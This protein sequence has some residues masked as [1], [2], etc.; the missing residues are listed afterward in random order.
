MTSLWTLASWQLLIIQTIC[1]PYFLGSSHKGLSFFAI[2]YTVVYSSFYLVKYLFKNLMPG[3]KLPLLNH[4]LLYLRKLCSLCRN[5]MIS[6]V[7]ADIQIRTFK[8]EAHWFYLLC[9]LGQ[10]IKT[11]ITLVSNTVLK[12]N[13]TP[14]V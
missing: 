8:S 10:V 14:T 7:N 12:K 1:Q 11:A 9:T 2:F 5:S 3:I 13:R 4:Y 6:W